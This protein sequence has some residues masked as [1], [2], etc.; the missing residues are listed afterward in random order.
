[1]SVR[2][3]HAAAEI[4]YRRTKCFGQFDHQGQAACGPRRAIRDD[5]GWCDAPED[6]AYNRPV[7]LPYP[8]SAEALVR[9]DGL[10]DVIVILGHNDDPPRPGAGSAIFLHCAR[11]DYG[12]TLGCVA[13]AKP[14]LLT[15]LKA[16]KP[17][18]TLGVIPG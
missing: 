18:D 11:P 12:P 7:R 5:D 3:V 8:A 10:Y 16:M 6:P 13:L 2:E 4:D 14:D 17:G 1:M 9:E 15:L